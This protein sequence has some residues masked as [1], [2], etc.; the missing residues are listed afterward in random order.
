MRAEDDSK[1]DYTNPRNESEFYQPHSPDY[2]K[3]D[4]AQFCFTEHHFI[5]HIS[6][7]IKDMNR[8]IKTGFHYIYKHANKKD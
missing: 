6:D 1:I 8:F 2:Y 3:E 4:I 7:V 5:Q